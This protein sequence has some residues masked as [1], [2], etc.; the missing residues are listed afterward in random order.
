M[1]LAIIHRI[2]T[3]RSAATRAE[4]PA[5]AGLVSLVR[6][7]AADST[8]APVGAVLAGRARP[9]GVYSIEADAWPARSDAG[10]PD[11]LRHGLELRR[12]AALPGRHHDGHGLLALLDSHVQLG[13]EPAT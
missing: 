12:V 6:D 3:R 2:E 9:I 5:V 4:L 11:I 8:A 10:Y 13:G 7:G 1:A